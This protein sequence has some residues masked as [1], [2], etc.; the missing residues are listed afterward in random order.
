[1]KEGGIETVVALKDIT[2]GGAREGVHEDRF[3]EFDATVDAFNRFSELRTKSQYAQD[4]ELF[5]GAHN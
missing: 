2:V 4:A 1:L 3:E 5:T